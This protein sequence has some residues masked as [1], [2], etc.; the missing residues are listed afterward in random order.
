MLAGA[1]ADKAAA[2]SLGEIGS[3]MGTA[4]KPNGERTPLGGG[5]GFVVH[6]QRFHDPPS[7]LAQTVAI[8]ASSLGLRD[9]KL[10]SVRALQDAVMIT[11]RTDTPRRMALH[12]IHDGDLLRTLLGSP[13]T[14]YEGVY[15]ELDGPKGRPVFIVMSASRAGSGGGWIRPGLGVEFPGPGRRS[16]TRSTRARKHLRPTRLVVT[17]VQKGTRSFVEGSFSLLRIERAAA[18]WSSSAACARRTGPQ[19]CLRAFVWSPA[20]TAFAFSTGT[21]RRVAAPR[22]EAIHPLPPA[23]LP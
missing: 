18:A 7:R 8:G 12:L 11:A 22:S 20:L 16:P 19:R 14:D 15:F 10:D 23:P 4:V 3:V 6:D 9:S 1:V 13:Q 2:S 5:L 17:E 21:A